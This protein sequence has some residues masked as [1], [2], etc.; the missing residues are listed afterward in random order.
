MNDQDIWL[1]GEKECHDFIAEIQISLT[2]DDA[3][4]F[5]MKSIV[6]QSLKSANRELP[7][8]FLPLVTYQE[9]R[10]KHAAD[11]GPVEPFDMDEAHKGM[12]QYPN[13]RE[14]SDRL[15]QLMQ[16]NLNLAS[17][18]VFQTYNFEYVASDYIGTALFVGVDKDQLIKELKR[19]L[20]KFVTP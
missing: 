18:E 6:F 11:I 1:P 7:E 20:G 17:D 4:F 5:E 12:R 13:K 15:T 16:L 10:F 2:N 14:I 9:R 19:R 8:S 3:P